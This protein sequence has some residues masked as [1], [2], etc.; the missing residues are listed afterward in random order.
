MRR[1]LFGANVPQVGSDYDTVKRAVLECEKHG[2][3]FVWIADHFQDTTPSRPYLECW[4]TLSA[5]AAETKRIRL[6]TVLVNNLF[7]HPS[8]LAKM[9]ST[10]DVI[11]RGR[12][13][14]GIGAGWYSEECAAFGVPFPKPL[15]RIQRLEET[16]EIVKRLWT[17]DTVTFQGKYYSLKDAVLEPKPVQKP[18]PPIWTGIMYG[19]RRMLNVIAKH[20]DLWTISSLYLPTPK[21]HQEMKKALDEACRTVGRDPN[22]IQQALGIGCVIAEDEPRLREKAERFKPISLNVKD[23][24]TKQMR[25]EG[26][27]QQL[28][29]KLRAYT[30][31]GV[32]CFVMNFP[33]VATLEP[34]RLFSEKVMPAFRGETC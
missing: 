30:S 3:D 18:H 16:F 9:S 20:A 21:E 8:L 27:P 29:E 22:Q 12:L 23:Y 11:S 5:L 10:L 2:F 28:I 19:K 4:T 31:V 34:V 15:E 17:Q 25:L 7:R 26:T 24:S 13:N 14:L 1:I 33:D 6:S 32:T